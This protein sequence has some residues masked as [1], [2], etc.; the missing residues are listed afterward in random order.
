MAGN[1][2]RVQRAQ[3][4]DVTDLPDWCLHIGYAP[5]WTEEPNDSAW[6]HAVGAWIS[7]H[8]PHLIEPPEAKRAGQYVQEFFRERR[9]RRR[10]AEVAGLVDA[11]GGV[12]LAPGQE[13]LPAGP[14]APSGPD[15][16]E[17]LRTVE[18]PYRPRRS[19]R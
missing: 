13:R 10:Q 4:L 16:R 6:A 1:R 14:P 18:E 7:E 8:A 9:R 17:I 2:S 12:L 11:G 15:P 3:L 19:R 5:D